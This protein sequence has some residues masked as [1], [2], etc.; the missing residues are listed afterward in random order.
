MVSNMYGHPRNTGIPRINDYASAL[1]L[2]EDTKPIRGR[3]EDTRPLGYREKVDSYQINFLPMGA[4]E[5]ILYRTPVVTFYENG[6]VHIRHDGWNSV[7]TC[8]FIG[9]VL[10]IHSYISNYKLCVGFNYKDYV[11]PK[12]G[13]TIK[14]NANWVY[15]P[16]NPVPVM[17]HAINR[18][19][20]NNVRLRYKPF[21]AYVSS[22]CRLKGDS[23][24]PQS[25]AER[26][27]GLNKYGSPK[28]G[29]LSR[30]GYQEWDKDVQKFFALVND[31]NKEI[32]RAHV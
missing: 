17:G 4:V 2:W 8:N 28:S 32:G 13:L 16:V 30:D 7:S 12:E 25:E 29:D 11:V 5:C 15:E 24:Y 14:R 23:L 10:G 6:E 19:G 31:T 22:M 1:K 27:F 26:L 18:K 3:D 20:A 21:S 9:E